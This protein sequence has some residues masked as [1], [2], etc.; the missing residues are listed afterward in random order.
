M[1]PG[2]D[3]TQCQTDCM[4]FDA[5]TTDYSPVYTGPLCDIEFQLG[6]EWV[7]LHLSSKQLDFGK[8]TVDQQLTLKSMFACHHSQRLCTNRHN[9][10]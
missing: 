4:R 7:L 8:S 2:H 3:M 10:T 5:S 6:E 9:Q 1:L